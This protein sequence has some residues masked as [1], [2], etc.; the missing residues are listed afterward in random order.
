MAFTKSSLLV[1]EWKS[2]V[3]VSEKVEMKKSILAVE[4]MGGSCFTN[5]HFFNSHFTINNIFE[6]VVAEH[7]ITT[8][9]Q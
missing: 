3:D 1:T 5:S 6:A 7:I 4:K 9:K 2:R 8:V